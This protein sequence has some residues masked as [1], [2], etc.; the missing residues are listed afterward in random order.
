M[1]WL[2]VAARHPPH[3]LTIITC[4][5]RNVYSAVNALAGHYNNFG[6]SAPVPKKRLE[7]LVKVRAGGDGGGCIKDDCEAY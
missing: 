3:P 1:P 2:R 7:R 6:T 5:R 4:C